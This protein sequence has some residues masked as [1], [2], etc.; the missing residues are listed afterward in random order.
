ML[1]DWRRLNTPFVLILADLDHFKRI[2]DAHS[3]QAGDRVLQA[4][5][6]GLQKLSRNGD[7]VGRFGGDE[8]AILMP[9]TTLEA[10]MAVATSMQR[11]ISEKAFHV[12]VRNGEV[13][14]S[15]SM[16]VAVSMAGDSDETILQRADQALYRSKNAGRNQVH[17]QETEDELSLVG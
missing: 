17:C 9:N 14:I 16:G 11:G 8:F 5:A 12:S 6:K 2:N 15:F 4:A 1:D 13:S 7:F 3:H 10:G